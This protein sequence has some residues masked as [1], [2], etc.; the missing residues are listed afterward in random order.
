MADP[1]HFMGILILHFV[2]ISKKI[3]SV[4]DACNFVGPPQ[5]SISIF[6]YE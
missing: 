5:T 2:K 3:F 4:E 1:A 6:H